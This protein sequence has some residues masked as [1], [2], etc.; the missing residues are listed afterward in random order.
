[1]TSGSHRARSPKVLHVTTS[2]SSLDLLLRPQL[3]AIQAA[4][5]EVVTASAPGRYVAAVEA[6]GIRHIP[7]HHAT[8]SMDVKRDAAVVREFFGILRSE[9]PDIVH[10]HNPKPGWFGRVTSRLAGVP[11]VVNT[12]H[13]LYATASDPRYKRYIVYSLERAAAAFSDL[14][15]VQ[16]SEDVDVLR[17]LHVPDDRLVTLG[18]GVDLNRFDVPDPAVRQ[19]ARAALGIADDE[20]A[21]GVVGRLVWEKGLREVFEASRRLPT[22]VPGLRFL[23]AGPLDPEK[24]DG[25]LGP[26]LDQITRQS[27]VEFLGERTDIESVYD[28]LD[29]YLLASH[30]EGF[31]RSAM[32]A[33]ASGVPVVASNIRGCRQVVEHGVTG[34]LFGVGRVGELCDAVAKLSLDQSRRERMSKE[35]R[36]KAEADFDQDRVIGTVLDAYDRLLAAKGIPAAQG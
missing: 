5:Y 1:M 18:N 2:D 31:P 30:R 29:V 15:L 36:R 25:L 6:S 4:G 17:K 22:R 12:V 14:E 8:R 7:L 10:T 23:V 26:D 3:E 16:S 34:L 9:R 33:A 35:A 21:V 27:G 24:A 13:G 19:A 20:I 32:E 28:A 11:V